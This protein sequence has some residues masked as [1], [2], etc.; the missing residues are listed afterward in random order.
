M[1]SVY[2]L[3]F[4]DVCFYCYRIKIIDDDVDVS[5]TFNIPEEELFATNE[6]APQIVGIT[7]DRPPELRIADYRQSDVWQPVGDIVNNPRIIDTKN[8]SINL[9]GKRKTEK[10]S[11][12]NSSKEKIREK[13]S[14]SKK[15]IQQKSSAISIHTSIQGSGSDSSPPR[16]PKGRSDD[17]SPVRN[18]RQKGLDAPEKRKTDQD[19]SPPR[20]TK[21]EKSVSPVRSWKSEDDLSPPRKQRMETNSITLKKSRWDED[22]S[23]ARKLRSEDS[24]LR[25]CR[26]DNND[27]SPPRRRK[28]ENDLSPPRK[29]NREKDL[30]SPRKFRK[31]EDSD[32]RKLEK[33]NKETTVNPSGKERKS[34]WTKSGSPESKKMKKTLD[35][36][37]AGLQNARDLI[38]ET[39]KSK[40]RE[41]SLF[42][43]LSIEQSGANAAPI[44]RDR[45]SGKIR[46]LVEEQEQQRKKQEEEDKKKEQYSKWGKGL[47]QIEDINE[48]IA[49]DLHEMN[50]PLAR[51]ADD[52]D[53]ERYLKEQE[54][55]G[56][57]M[58]PY[59]KKKKK[60]EA[61]ASGK[62]TKLMY[63][64][65]FM[66]NR[67]GIRPGYRWDGVD[68]SNGYEKKWF[69]VQNAKKAQQEDAYKWST[70]DM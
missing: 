8:I 58:L 47:K 62:P 37:T 16:R 21:S 14:D 57:T 30:S 53:L 6:D 61:V 7:D 24:P 66:P 46:N 43:S 33:G 20:K 11:G 56:D 31:V 64:G 68:R 23:P 3:Y 39:E 27:L 28:K 36:K 48:K 34:R 50:K 52:E 70:D 12:L 44:L 45:K 38:L 15:D 5:S 67:F 60:K 65:E 51:Y 4:E 54:R 42:N 2:K 26:S 22:L 63:E 55:E 49:E 18:P 10:Q 40:Q 9:T 41:D 29:S 35:G 1:I 59:I 17:Y 25:N 13:S 32:I 69:E 19:L